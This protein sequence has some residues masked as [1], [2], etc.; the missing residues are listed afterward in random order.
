[1]PKHSKRF[2]ELA[3]AVDTKQVY[4]PVEALE[5]VKK[6]ANAKFD[7]T[8]D[9]AVRLGVDPR[10]GDQMV[11]GTTSLPFGTGKARRV[12]VFAKGEKA[13]EAEAAGADVVG[14]EDLV[15][16]IRNGWREFDVLVASPDMMSIVS[17]LGRTLGPRMPNPKS[18]TVTTDIAKVVREI[19]SAS[20][21]EYR[22]EKAGIIH[23]AIGKVSF[24]TEQLLDN[25]TVLLNAL[26][27]ARPQAAKGRYL[28][29]ITVSA[30]MGPG[31][32]IDPQ[33]AQSISEKIAVAG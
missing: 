11:R 31:F 3:R 30:T 14:A 16:Q 22:V 28:R 27:K 2:N 26:L 17:R 19:K 7:E 25:F 12:A 23:M 18:G 8:V 33:V 21:V 9:V 13:A 15:E 10:H 5:M 29:G 32:S 6:T 4:E 24:S 20:R 1:M